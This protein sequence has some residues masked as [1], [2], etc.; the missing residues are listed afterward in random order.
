MK[1][2]RPATDEDFKVKDWIELRNG[3]TISEEV[4]TDIAYGNR[5]KAIR[6]LREMSGQH[7]SDAAKIVDDMQ[8]KFRA[9]QDHA[10][11]KTVYVEY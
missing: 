11:G 7:F 1:Y 9:K 10:M 8:K 4:I 6:G 2:Y 5:A 3:M